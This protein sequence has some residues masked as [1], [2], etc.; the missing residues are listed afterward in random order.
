MQT[1]PCKLTAIDGKMVYRKRRKESHMSLELTK[2][3]PICRADSV[4]VY[5]AQLAYVG[6]Q[7]RRKK[8]LAVY[9]VF[10]SS[11]LLC[12][13][14]CHARTSWFD[15]ILRIQSNRPDN[16]WRLCFVIKV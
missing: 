16:K 12:C 2:Q 10:V 15:N 13:K 1:K 3:Q 7:N 9:K 6:S 5:M 11:E 4:F 14:Q 8:T